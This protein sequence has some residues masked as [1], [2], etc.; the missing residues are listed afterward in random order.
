MTDL[1][2]II[3]TSAATD[4]MQPAD[5]LSILGASRDNNAKAGVTGMLVFHAG[6]FLQVL[7][8]P[9]EP[10]E[11]TY[12]R[13][14]TDRRHTNLKL[15]FRGKILE[16][17]FGDWEMGFPDIDDLLKGIPGFRDYATELKDLTL[18]PQ[19]ARQTLKLFMAGDYRQR[20]SG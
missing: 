18:T 17:E 12:A 11:A 2:Q 3:Y 6:S 9:I 1:R 16:R 7:E 5:L 10:V 8:G 4:R 14:H 15:L 19:R 20:R 13:I